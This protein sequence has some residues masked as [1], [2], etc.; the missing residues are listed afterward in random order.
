MPA[1]EARAAEIEHSLASLRAESVLTGR[2]HGL[3][4]DS[5][6]PHYLIMAVPPAPRQRERLLGLASS[7]HTNFPPSKVLYG[8]TAP[9]MMM[10]IMSTPTCSALTNLTSWRTACRV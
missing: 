8:G 1:L 6:A 2:S 7:R 3:H 10:S 5:W 9:Q 4:P